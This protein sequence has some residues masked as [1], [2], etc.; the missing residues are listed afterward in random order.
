MP[1][2]HP[3][4]LFILSSVRTYK[5]WLVFYLAF[6]LWGKIFSI[7]NCAPSCV[8]FLFRVFSGQSKC[9]ACAIQISTITVTKKCLDLHEDVWGGCFEL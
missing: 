2:P 8:L 9:G 1:N 6:D 7:L 3:C 5:I 4:G